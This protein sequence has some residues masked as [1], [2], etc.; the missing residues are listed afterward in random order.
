MPRGKSVRKIIEYRNVTERERMFLEIF[1]DEAEREIK[2]VAP[3]ETVYLSDKDIRKYK[4]DV[5]FLEGRIVP[6]GSEQEVA[7]THEISDIMTPNQIKFFIKNTETSEALKEKIKDLRS[8]ETVRRLL[9]EAKSQDRS[10]SFI[11][12][13]EDK[14]KEVEIYNEKQEK[15]EKK[16]ED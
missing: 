2:Q 6:V 3:N 13:L 12:S 14:L 4:D 1:G 16:D 8:R 10:Y 9:I 11:V 5:R 7:S 15:K